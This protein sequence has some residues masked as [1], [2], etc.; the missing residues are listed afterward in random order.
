MK[1]RF[2]ALDVQTLERRLAPSSSPATVESFDSTPA[3]ALPANWS[4]WSSLGSP[5][6][7]VAAGLSL[8]GTQALARTAN[9]ST[10]AA[11]AWNNA[12]LPA[13]V[14]VSAAVYLNTLIPTQ[15]LARGSGL[16]TATPSYY[17]LSLT[18]GLQAQLV[19][20][21]NGV[22]TVLGT[23]N[24]SGWFSD[25]WVDAALDLQGNVL[26]AQIY[27][28]DTQ[29]YLNAQGRWQ[30]SQ[31]WAI[32]V[33]DTV[34]TGP[35]QAGVGRPSS[36]TGTI[37][38]DDFG[39]TLQAV[40]EGFDEV[41]V[42]GL[43]AGWTQ[44]SSTGGSPFGV[45]V[46][47]AVSAPNGLTAT[48]TV[49]T[50]AARA[51]PVA[52]TWTNVEASSAVY[53]NGLI[54]AQVFGRGTGLAGS[55]PSYYAASI[56]SG[57]R[58]QLLCVDQGVTTVL[59]TVQSVDWVNSVWV[60]VMLHASGSDLRA[61][62]YRMDQGLYL[63][64]QG[65]WQTARTWAL[66]A[67]DTSITGPGQVGVARPASYAGQITFDD[68]SALSADGDSQLPTVTI[69]SPT[70][71]ATLTGT[72]QVQAQASDNVGVV[73][74]Q[75][76]VD[77]TR[78]AFSTV[79]PYGWSLDSTTMSN[80]TH[81]LDVLAYDAAGNVARASV[82]VTVYNPY[83]LPQVVIPQHYS[84]IRLADLAYT[85][86]P[87]TATEDGLLRNS[88]DLVISDPALVSH[89]ASVA[90]Q[91]PQMLYTNFST[92]YG[93]LL[94]DWLTYADA[95]GISRESA[96]YHVTRATPYLGDSPS[97][98]PVDWFWSVSRGGV[99]WTDL[100]QQARH[101]AAGGVA[102]G[103]AGESVVIGYPEEFREINV[104]LQSAAAG[105][106][107]A[108]LEYP[109]Q[110]DAAGN[111]TAWTPLPL[112]T[113]TTS[114]LTRTG[115]V[116]FDP[117]PD[118]KPAS[119]NGSAP[120]YYVRYRTSVGGTA[121]VALSM[122]GRDYTGAGNGDSGVVPAFDYAA[123]LNHDGYLNNTE[124]AHA[125]PGMT[126]RFAY[127][128]RAP[129][130]NYGE[131]RFA[132]NPSAAGFRAWAVGY[133]TRLLAGQ[134]A[135]AGLFIDNSNA[136]VP[137]TT[138]AVAEP[139]VSYATDYG[140][141][142]NTVARAAAPKWLLANTAGGA[143]TADPVVSRVTAY[144]EEF[145]LRPLT[146]SYLQFEDAAAL[147]AHRAALQSPPAYAVLDSLPAGGSPTDPRTQMATLAYYYLLADPS[148]TFLDLYGGYSPAS[149][150]SQHWFGAVTYNVGQPT[151]TWSIFASGPDPADLSKTYRVY[152]RPYSNALVLYKPRSSTA[153]GSA[154][155]STAD[156]TAT[157]HQLPGTYRPL[158]ADGTLGAPLTSITLRNGE[159][160]VLI[161][162]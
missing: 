33:N 70:P 26:R 136:S 120:L 121:P 75:V 11:R 41:P 83:A 134:P 5:S 133:G 138:G 64:A 160:A 76:D 18:R 42:G 74:V 77:G 123:D 51:W 107:S 92:L 62:V 84:W 58:A 147:V 43:P 66:S 114:S 57:L 116:L 129:Y 127:E 46:G 73:R 71:G 159:G 155:G 44:W 67:T 128:S 156:N 82:V 162:A 21:S 52:S 109:T 150:W 145:A 113:D 40:A 4:Q 131:E 101:N 31:A 111:P 141:L 39:I 140:S 86:T 119:I 28:P 19:R 15:V 47:P 50:T 103:A 30:S 146:A 65:Q 137:V 36:Y 16:N 104:V 143:S 149:S 142:L 10:L 112:L 158:Q 154:S 12:S 25:R 102:F 69:T 59:G 37:T 100:T 68:F 106:W 91:T 94:T 55:T 115:Q 87:F 38:I 153:N 97:S 126:A 17:A 63:N 117:P 20:V 9:R 32:Q 23:L 148:R 118:W 8:S 6:F 78:R 108:A 110:V 122:L 7:A 139:T 144:F 53:L 124:Y 125:A 3:G 22:T 48:A 61:E 14:Q 24:S 95:H 90:P 49:S 130:V 93:T 105:G 96:F 99:T 2:T 161:K 13:D 35:G 72:V 60:R 79:G 132:T 27:R 54:P 85:G 157:V 45:S 29:Q 80:G 88:V 1:T 81:T 34:L 151:A 135:V 152:E 98:Q 89:V 56:T